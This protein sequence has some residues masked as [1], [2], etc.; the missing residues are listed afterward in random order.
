[1]NQGY[2]GTSKEQ[3]FGISCDDCG[4]IEGGCR[5]LNE[6][7]EYAHKT[8]EEAAGAWNRRCNHI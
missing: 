6:G 3:N 1:M 7:V 8:P 4:T 5:A 2:Y